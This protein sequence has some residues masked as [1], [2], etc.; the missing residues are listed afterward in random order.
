[1]NLLTLPVYLRKKIKILNLRA[2]K[3]YRITYLCAAKK[4]FP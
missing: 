4:P 3:A 2:A 1:M